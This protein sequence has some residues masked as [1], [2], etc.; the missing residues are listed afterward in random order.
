MTVWLLDPLPSNP[1]TIREV[2]HGRLLAT[3][4]TGNPTPSH[5]APRPDPN[6]ELDNATSLIDTPP[7]DTEAATP[8]GGPRSGTSACRESG[9]AGVDL[10]D[11]L[12]GPPSM[13]RREQ[14]DDGGVAPS[15]GEQHR[16]VGRSGSAFSKAAADDEAV[17]LVLL[18]PG[19]GLVSSPVLAAV[20]GGLGPRTVLAVLTHRHRGRGA[21]VDARPA[22]VVAAVAVGLDHLQHIV[23]IT[24]HHSTGG[25]PGG[26]CLGPD[27]S[28]FRRRP[29]P[30][31]RPRGDRR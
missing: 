1:A 20:A 5:R 8:T 4:A 26:W 7:I 30:A 24:R 27:I 15:V 19:A 25:E 21:L 14:R 28:L 12:A 16:N 11:A 18:D 13:P 3:L 31:H 23:T 9:T 10:G 29:A 22:L 17:G 2:L 6:D